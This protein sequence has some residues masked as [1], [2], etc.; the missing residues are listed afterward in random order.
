M[1]FGFA[2]KTAEREKQKSIQ[3]T[4]QREQ[5]IRKDAFFYR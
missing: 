3:V 4:G 5:E 2:E 1:G